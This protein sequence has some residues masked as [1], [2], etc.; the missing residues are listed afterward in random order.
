MR[1]IKKVCW[2]N[3]LDNC[4]GVVITQGEERRAYIAVVKGD[5]FKTDCEFIAKFG[6]PFPI[7]AAEL[8]MSKEGEPVNITVIP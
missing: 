4:I 3:T 2:F 1:T 5:D 7:A 6:S 8:L